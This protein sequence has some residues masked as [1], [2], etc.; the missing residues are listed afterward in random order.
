MTLL[1]TNLKTFVLKTEIGNFARECIM[2]EAKI[3]IQKT[4][5]RLKK[6]HHP[7]SFL[8]LTSNVISMK[9]NLVNGSALDVVSMNNIRF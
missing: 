7:G 8:K 5:C 2:T 9:L 6:K 1:E 3:F 4:F